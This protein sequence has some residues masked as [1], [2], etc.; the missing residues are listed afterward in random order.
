[1]Q[2]TAPETNTPS[3]PRWRHLQRLLDSLTWVR[4]AANAYWLL[5]HGAQNAT[6]DSAIRATAESAVHALAILLGLGN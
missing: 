1:M 5:K 2:P 3:R 4:A 6:A